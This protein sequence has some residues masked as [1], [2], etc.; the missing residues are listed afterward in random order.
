MKTREGILPVFLEYDQSLPQ[1]AWQCFHPSL[2]LS[3]PGLPHL[4]M[5]SQPNSRLPLRET[6]GELEISFRNQY[7]LLTI[8]TSNVTSIAFRALFIDPWRWWTWGIWKRRGQWF[9]DFC[10]F[11]VRH[12]VDKYLIDPYINSRDVYPIF[13]FCE[14]LSI[15]FSQT[16]FVQTYALFAPMLEGLIFHFAFETLLKHLLQVY[17]RTSSI[18]TCVHWGRGLCRERWQ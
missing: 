1:Q 2:H 12:E 16:P 6:E 4:E 9:A 13:P 11:F 17:F 15:F 3:T 8:S 18:K 7:S 5:D 10:L 14:Q